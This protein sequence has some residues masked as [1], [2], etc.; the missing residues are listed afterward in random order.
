MGCRDSLP[1]GRNSR[2]LNGLFRSIRIQELTAIRSAVLEHGARTSDPISGGGNGGSDRTCI[3]MAH[4]DAFSLQGL[5]KRRANPL[6]ATTGDYRAMVAAYRD[7]ARLRDQHGLLR[8]GPLD[9][10]CDDRSCS[11]PSP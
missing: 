7:P 9:A 10:L 2:V 4:G 11:S 1:H 3:W 5:S 6:L 8:G